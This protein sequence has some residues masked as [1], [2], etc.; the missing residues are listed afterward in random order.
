MEPVEQSFISILKRLENFPLPDVVRLHS[1]L[2]NLIIWFLRNATLI[3]KE[4]ILS[5]PGK[6]G[7]LCF[8]TQQH[9]HIYSDL[10]SSCCPTLSVFCHN[11][12]S[13]LFLVQTI[14]RSFSR[15]SD[16]TI[17]NVRLFV[18]LSVCL[19]YIKAPQLDIIIL[20]PSS[21]FIHPTFI[22]RL[23]RF[24]AYFSKQF[25]MSQRLNFEYFGHYM[26]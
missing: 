7:N 8:T 13:L 17:T 9:Y 6:C 21:L 25:M 18:C 10:F 16:S 15:K 24:S 3:T 26:K 4:N 19:S 20:H 12:L 23:L 5:F 2:D 22:S 11:Y 14:N 1:T